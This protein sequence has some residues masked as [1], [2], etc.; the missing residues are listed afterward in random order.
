MSQGFAVL[1][2]MNY[3]YFQPGHWKCFPLQSSSQEIC[4]GGEPGAGRHGAPAQGQQLGRLLMLELRGLPAIYPAI[5]DNLSP[6]Y[7]DGF[8]WPQLVG[9]A[10]YMPATPDQWYLH[11]L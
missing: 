3:K 9:T 7:W 11:N 10:G 6:N 8:L 1:R 2:E 5:K 4:G